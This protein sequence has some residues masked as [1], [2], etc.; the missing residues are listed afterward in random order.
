MQI[1]IDR[2][3]ITPI[4][5]ERHSSIKKTIFVSRIL[6]RVWS[7]KMSSDSVGSEFS[8]CSSEVTIIML[9]WNSNDWEI[10]I[11]SKVRLSRCNTR[12]DGQFIAIASNGEPTCV[13]AS[14]SKILTFPPA[15]NNVMGL[16]VTIT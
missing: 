16:A 6:D 10:R 7:T 13:P 11:G 12:V 14:K 4:K 8:H 2:S 9:S 1:R 3:V 5:K 15:A